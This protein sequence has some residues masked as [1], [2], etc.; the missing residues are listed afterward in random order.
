MTSGS[1]T[2]R[3]CPA[4]SRPRRR[5]H[6]SRVLADPLAWMVASGTARTL[7]LS[8]P[9]QN[10]PPHRPP[11]RGRRRVLNRRLSRALN[12]GPRRSRSRA[13][14]P[15]QRRSRSRALNPGRPPSPSLGP[16]LGPNLGLSQSR[17]RSPSRSLSRSPS[18]SPS[19][20]RSGRTPARSRLVPL[21]LAPLELVPRQ[22]AL[23]CCRT[24]TRA[25]RPSVAGSAALSPRWPAPR[26]S[27]RTASR[28][29]MSRR[30]PP[31]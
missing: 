30:L 31:R 25:L 7:A 20:W 26:P 13:L 8:R 24:T 6:A 12:P 17:R 23:R 19:A 2:S 15:G 27:G 11:R 5:R 9:A 18:R 1:R 10:H 4:W 28:C 29:L 21:E 16:N 14:N 3:R 22:P